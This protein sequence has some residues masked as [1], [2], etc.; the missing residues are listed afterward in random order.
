[1]KSTLQK[2]LLSTG[3]T[4][5][6]ALL[7]ACGGNAPQQTPQ[8]NADSIPPADTLGSNG[9]TL[10]QDACFTVAGHCEASC[11]TNIV[12]YH[13][14]TQSQFDNMNVSGSTGTT[15]TKTY[16][17]GLLANL[18]CEEND[19]I[20]ITENARTQVIGLSAVQYNNSSQ[21]PTNMSMFSPAFLNGLWAVYPTI[22][23]IEIFRAVTVPGNVPT[24]IFKGKAGS[25]TVYLG[26][27]TQTY[28]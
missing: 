28:P 2:L 25:T 10:Q 11:S 7:V 14:I 13:Q 1:M 6:I 8:Q 26:D 17:N 18:S 22:D 16:I 27:M 12:A 21:F 24:A 9:D 15:F 4:A 23:N 20:D 5:G 19:Y 3:I